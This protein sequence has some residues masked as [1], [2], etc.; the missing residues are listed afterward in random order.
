MEY[1]V[2]EP[3]TA[4]ISWPKGHD[5]FFFFIDFFIIGAYVY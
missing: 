4:Y 5:F 3:S 2:G 1:E